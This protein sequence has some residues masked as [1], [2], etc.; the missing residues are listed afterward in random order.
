MSHKETTNEVLDQLLDIINK[1]K[2]LKLDQLQ[3]MIK[4]QNETIRKLKEQLETS[5]ALHDYATK[6]QMILSRKVV[7]MG[8]NPSAGSRL[9][10]KGFQSLEDDP[11]SEEMIKIYNDPIWDN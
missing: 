9:C 6:E 3:N 11:L 10:I 7:E 5:Q 4:E 8:Y 1:T 2:L